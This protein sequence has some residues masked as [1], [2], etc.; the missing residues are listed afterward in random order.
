VQDAAECFL[1]P[2]QRGAARRLRLFQEF[3]AR[4]QALGGC[5][6]PPRELGL[7]RFE[8][9]RVADL[10]GTDQRRFLLDD[11][12]EFFDQCGEIVDRPVRFRGRRYR[13]HDF[14]N[15]CSLRIVS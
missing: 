6:Q 11:G 10:A 1:Q 2:R 14:D 8:G 15:P 3:R 5:E 4:L 12:C 13:G 7:G 9:R